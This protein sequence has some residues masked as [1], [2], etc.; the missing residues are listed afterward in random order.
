MDHYLAGLNK[1]SSDSAPAIQ[2]PA[3]GQVPGHSFLD[4]EPDDTSN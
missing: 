1:N 2:P 4:L 3:D